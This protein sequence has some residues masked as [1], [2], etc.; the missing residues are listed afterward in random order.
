MNHVAAQVL[1]Q[2]IEQ[3][4]LNLGEAGARTTELRTASDAPP[5]HCCSFCQRHNKPFDLPS[6]ASAEGGS[7]RNDDEAEQESGAAS[8]D[9]AYKRHN[10][11]AIGVVLRPTNWH[12]ECKA[13][14]AR[15]QNGPTGGDPAESE[16]HRGVAEQEQ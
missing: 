10:F 15:G 14:G 13:E 2:C 8:D 11:V 6:A 1:G 5:R 12:S 3:L 16:T 7:P 9:W 4:N